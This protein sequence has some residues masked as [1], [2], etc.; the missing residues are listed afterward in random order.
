MLGHRLRLA[1]RRLDDLT[2]PV[3]CVLDRPIAA[4]HAI[5]ISG[6]KFWLE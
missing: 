6:V 1:L 2:E 4:D 3:L 5:D